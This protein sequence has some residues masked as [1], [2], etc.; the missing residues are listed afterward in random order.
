MASSPKRSRRLARPPSRRPSRRSRSAGR[1]SS[2]VS[3][4]SMARLL[5]GLYLEDRQRLHRPLVEPAG[6]HLGAPGDADLE[7]GGVG[8][9]DDMGLEAVALGPLRLATG[10]GEEV[11]GL[12]LHDAGVALSEL[13]EAGVAVALGEALLRRPPAVGTGDGAG[14]GKRQRLAQALVEFEP[15]LAGA[16]RSEEHTS[17][18][19]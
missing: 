19:Q 17:E 18:L 6:G 14:P 16:Q 8:Q 10:A 13:P 15:L 3:A 2:A 12:R 5:A 9:V 11:A 1:A 7:A 4:L